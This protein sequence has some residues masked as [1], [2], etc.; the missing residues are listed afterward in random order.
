MLQQH[1]PIGRMREGILVEFPWFDAF[2]SNKRAVSDSIA[3]EKAS[4]LFNLAAVCSQQS[5]ASDLTT[6]G[7]LKAAA[8]H[9]QVLTFHNFA[10]TTAAVAAT[11]AACMRNLH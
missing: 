9:F 3:Y 2:Q 10:A 11:T 8:K 6:D 5:L 7:G 1:F 4:I